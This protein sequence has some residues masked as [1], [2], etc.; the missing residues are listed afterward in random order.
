MNKAE[1]CYRDGL[2]KWLDVKARTWGDLT[3]ALS[4]PIVGHNKIAMEI[5]EA[6]IQ[7]VGSANSS[8]SR[9]QNGK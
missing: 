3:E 2:S 8:A 6:Y 5:E 1:D 7:P 9:Q 4:S